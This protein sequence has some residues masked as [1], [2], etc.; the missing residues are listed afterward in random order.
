[1]RKIGQDII[2]N[3]TDVE[4]MKQCLIS[5]VIRKYLGYSQMWRVS[6]KIWQWEMINTMRMEITICM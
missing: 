1:M 4:K 6:A 2:N 3:I 5:E